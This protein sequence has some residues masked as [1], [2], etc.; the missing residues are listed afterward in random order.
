V[1]RYLTTRKIVGA[2]YT[3]SRKFCFLKPYYWSARGIRRKWFTSLRR[4]GISG[5]PPFLK[6]GSTQ[7][8]AAPPNLTRLSNFIEMIVKL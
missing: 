8:P 5:S 6:R 2:S 7:H 3:G 4:T 1:G